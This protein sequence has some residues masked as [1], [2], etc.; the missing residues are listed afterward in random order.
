VS[1][2]QRHLQ[3]VAGHQQLAPGLI[4]FTDQ[5]SIGAAWITLQGNP[6]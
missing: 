6:A 2:S 3:P 5:I 4:Q 1:A